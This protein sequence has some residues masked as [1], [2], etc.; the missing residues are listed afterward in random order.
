M[1]IKIEDIVDLYNS[2]NF[3]RALNSVNKYIKINVKN[4]QA[5]NLKGVILRALGRNNEALLNY[6]KAIKIKPNDLNAYNNKANILRQL[7]RYKEAEKI[8]KKTLEIDNSYFFGFF[9]LSQ[10]YNEIGNYNESENYAL[11]ALSINNNSSQIYIE[12]GISQKNLGKIDDSIKNFKKYLEFYPDSTKIKHQ[13]DILE[14]NCP[15]TS[16]DDFIEDVFDSYAGRFDEHLINSLN[17]SGPRFIKKIIRENFDKN[18]IF[19]NIIDLGC[20]TGLNGNFLKNICDNL[21]G[22]DL[23]TNMLEKA[24]EKNIYDRLVKS[25][26]IDFLQEKKI[27]YDLFIAADVFI[28]TGKLDKIFELIKLRSKKESWI[29]FTIENQKNGNY[30]LQKSGRYTHSINYIKNLC[31]KNSFIINICE[32]FDLRLQDNEWV[33]GNIFL[34]NI[35]K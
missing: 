10:L 22:V 4:N 16:P 12:L 24:K 3:Q 29:I 18:K 35:F 31:K 9:N 17:Y 11:K 34:I 7:K 20:G 1:K 19:E 27:Q 25:N 26:F 28:Y 21:V 5:Y 15:E 33:D 30:N 32:N 6:D 23:S 13:I 8:Y 14:G 2:K